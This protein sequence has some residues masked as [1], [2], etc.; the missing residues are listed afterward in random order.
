MNTISVTYTLLFR[1]SF[2]HH[3]QWTKCGM[4]FNVKTGRRIKQTESKGSIGYKIDGK[5]YPRTKLR[6]CL[7]KIPNEDQP[8]WSYIDTTPNR[9]T[10][11]QC[12]YGDMWSFS[13]AY[14]SLCQSVGLPINRAV[15][16]PSYRSLVYTVTRWSSLQRIW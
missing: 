13:S 6:E 2:A 5:F 11:R 7:E 4:C 9:W 3:Y 15:K 14:C 16:R 1:L 10:L 12:M 8:F